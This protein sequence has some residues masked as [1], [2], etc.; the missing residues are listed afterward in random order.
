M[1]GTERDLQ[2]DINVWN[3]VLT[4]SDMLIK[5]IAIVGEQES[6]N[7]EIEGIKIEQVK[8]LNYLGA[9]L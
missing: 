6:I 7:I 1:T 8:S 2:T 4:R 3:D 9:T 5:V